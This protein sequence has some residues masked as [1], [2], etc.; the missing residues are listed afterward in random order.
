MEQ[1]VGPL[2]KPMSTT[3]KRSAQVSERI[4]YLFIFC[5]TQK[6]IDCEHCATRTAFCGVRVPC[7]PDGKGWKLNSTCPGDFYDFFRKMNSQSP[8]LFLSTGEP[9]A[10]H[11]LCD[12]PCFSRRQLTLDSSLP[13]AFDNTHHLFRLG[14]LQILQ[15][16]Q[17]SPRLVLVWLGSPPP[18]HLSSER[19]QT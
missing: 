1:Q 9:L 19:P 4:F 18:P 10:K 12:L 3:I 2:G 15:T 14:W 11:K 17:L 6:R 5:K 13:Y 8:A 16:S 7:L